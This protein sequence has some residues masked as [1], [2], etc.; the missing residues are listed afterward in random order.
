MIRS[1]TEEDREN[2]DR[3]GTLFSALSFVQSLP[4]AKSK[5]S[6]LV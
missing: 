6:V 5:L 1:R 4:E 2:E 3:K